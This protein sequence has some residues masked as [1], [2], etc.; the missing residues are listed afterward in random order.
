MLRRTGVRNIIH[1][2]RQAPHVAKQ[3]DQRHRLLQ[4][5]IHAEESTHTISYSLG[6]QPLSPPNDK[7]SLDVS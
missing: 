7:L 3:D 5:H 2:K 6:R 1:A 4:K